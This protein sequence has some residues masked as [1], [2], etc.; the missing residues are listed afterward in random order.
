MKLVT[1][2]RLFTVQSYF[3][4]TDDFLDLKERFEVISK[5]RQSQGVYT[6]LRFARKEEGY[7]EE[8]ALTQDLTTYWT[9]VKPPM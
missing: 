6:R 4:P 1:K 3:L 8:D 5:A 7:R 2:L 9:V